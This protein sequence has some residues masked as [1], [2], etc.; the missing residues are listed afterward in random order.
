MDTTLPTLLRRM[1]AAAAALGLSHRQWAFAAG[2]RPETV[3]RLRRRGDCDLSTLEA[4]ARAAGLALEATPAPAVRAKEF[5]H[6]PTRYG[7]EEEER[8]LDLCLARGPDLKR[9][10]AMGPSFFMG[11]L[12]VMMAD[13]EG[14]DRA[15]Y[16]DLAEALHPGVTTVEAF[17]KWLERSPVRP[18]RFLPMLE[19][20]HAQASKSPKAA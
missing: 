20:W 3:S 9:W 5:A 7:R 13:V 11:G 8:L 6:M 15:R 2:V 17:S 18:S 10:R 1:S 14:Y 19:Q 16:L 4:L 12:A